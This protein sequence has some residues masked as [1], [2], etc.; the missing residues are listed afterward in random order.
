MTQ[1]QMNVISLLASSIDGYLRE[2]QPVRAFVQ[3]Q[4]LNDFLATVKVIK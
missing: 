1:E 4:K 2:N 3:T